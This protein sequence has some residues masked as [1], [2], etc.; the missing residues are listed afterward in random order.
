[1]P[2][3]FKQKGII[4]LLI[5]RSSLTYTVTPAK[6]F[7][8]SPWKANQRIQKNRNIRTSSFPFVLVSC[9]CYNESHHKC[10]G[11]NNTNVLLYG[12]GGQKLES[13]FPQP[14]SQVTAAGLFPPESGAGRGGGDSFLCFLPRLHSLHSLAHGPFLIFKTSRAASSNLCFCHHTA[15]SLTDVPLMKTLWVHQTHVR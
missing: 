9:C 4:L 14:M 1:M 6:S 15:F 7:P 8:M 10:S 13:S 12:S 2:I 11:L 3:L 5:W